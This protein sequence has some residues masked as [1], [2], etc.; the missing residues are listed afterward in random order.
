MEA[1]SSTTRDA[2]GLTSP[3]S[4]SLLAPSPFFLG[5]GRS[6]GYAKRSATPEPEEPERSGSGSGSSDVED[7]ESDT[8]LSLY[9]NQDDLASVPFAPVPPP[10]PPSSL[11]GSSSEST[12]F[13]LDSPFPRHQLYRPPVPHTSPA[14]QQHLQ[15]QQQQ[16]SP[17]HGKE[18]N[19]ARAAAAAQ[20]HI[21]ITSKPTFVGFPHVSS[22]LAQSDSLADV[23]SNQSLVVAGKRRQQDSPRH[24]EGRGDGDNDSRSSSDLDVDLDLSFDFPT[25]SPRHSYA[26]SSLT[27][28]VGGGSLGA[29][30]SRVTGRVGRPDWVGIPVS[31]VSSVRSSL[32]S[33]A[34]VESE[35]A[36][37]VPTPKRRVRSAI[38]LRAAYLAAERAIDLEQT[39][40]TIPMSPTTIDEPPPSKPGRMGGSARAE[41]AR[42]TNRNPSLN[43]GE[44]SPPR[45][46]R[47]STSSLVR[48]QSL[49]NGFA[50]NPTAPSSPS[51][52]ASPASPFAT[53]ANDRRRTRV[54]LLPLKIADEASSSGPASS[55]A[56]PAWSLAS[57]LRGRSATDA[58]A[59]PVSLQP[60]WAEE[61]KHGVLSYLGRRPREPT[62][63][64]ES[65]Q[66]AAFD[67][68]RGSNDTDATSPETSPVLPAHPANNPGQQ[69]QHRRI[70]KATPLAGLGLAFGDEDTGDE[71]R[72]LPG[73]SRRVPLAQRRHHPSIPSLSL[74]PPPKSDRSSSESTRS[75][76][77]LS[78]PL[79]MDSARVRLQ[80]SSILHPSSRPRSPT[81]FGPKPLNLLVSET[82]PRATLPHQTTLASSRFSFTPAPLSLVK[83]QILRAA[84][85]D[86][87]PAP[88]HHRRRL[89][90]VSLKDLF[91]SYPGSLVDSVV[92]AKLLFLLGFL[93]GPW[94]WI[95]GGWWLREKD[96]EL[97]S[98]Q[99]TRC[100][101]PGCD[102]GRVVQWYS[103]AAARKHGSKALLP[104]DNKVELDGWVYVNRAAT[105]SSGGVVAVLVTVALWAAASA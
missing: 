43:L 77:R 51:S 16:P 96:G 18:N 95:M 81:S 2:A 100:R 53:D 37:V 25:P 40:V 41:W 22:L 50:F 49:G 68:P 35:P 15:H 91:T 6:R 98:T 39:S 102:C 1:S 72:S 90:V 12:T 46:A 61:A 34:D 88:S 89:S 92:P 57:L 83:D 80:D 36:P 103:I 38:E 66:Y 94:C 58:D 27:N 26:S 10:S 56:S 79:S 93:L 64:P 4:A 87:L 13:Q 55:L 59:S 76:R 8:F 17:Q 48:L 74:S 75:D 20:Q 45:S 44:G 28:A 85:Y 19:P 99:G 47:A 9:Q 7:E 69:K 70:S 84:G 105:V 65:S 11:S 3:S 23:R 101:E 14:K 29:A 52:P 104:G 30:P 71:V 31:P 86:V 60:S 21:R 63:S 5:G 67:S 32:E 73:S 97:W 54:L 33:T 62:T 24:G 82:M 42:R 78:R